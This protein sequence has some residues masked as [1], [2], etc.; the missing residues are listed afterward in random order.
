MYPPIFISGPHGSGK[1]T[2]VNRLKNRGLD[3]IESDFDIDFTVSFPNLKLLSN[4]ERSLLRLYHRI[5]ATTYAEKISREKTESC[6]LVNR[7]VYDS[8]AY[9]R[10]YLEFGWITGLEFETLNFIIKNFEY[11]PYVVVLNPPVSEI[12]KRLNIRE[13]MRTRPNRDKIFKLED[14]V[15]C[16][17]NL[18]TYFS[19]MKGMSN[20]LYLEDNEELEVEKFE[21]W[22]LGLQK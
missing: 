16:I 7:S 10:M 13:S 11:K 1:T 17:E 19:K 5:F 6:V 14:S 22:V 12:V 15:E 3:F 9:I 18:H 21:K 2:F 4:F 8:E 20:V